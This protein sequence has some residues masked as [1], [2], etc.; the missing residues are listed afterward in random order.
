MLPI[1]GVSLERVCDQWGYPA[2]FNLETPHKVNIPL[3][4]NDPK[5]YS[6]PVILFFG[7]LSNDPV[8]Q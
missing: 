2:L 1:D 4:K 8:M 5:T 6:A 3:S 7:L